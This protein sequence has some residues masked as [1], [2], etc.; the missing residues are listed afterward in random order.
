M[1][2]SDFI[3]AILVLV[4]ISCVVWALDLNPYSKQFQ[5]YSQSCDNMILEN[6]FCKGNWHDNPINTFTVSQYSDQVISKLEN[7]PESFI[8]KDCTIQDRKN[9][10]CSDES[11]QL[12]INV[13]DGLI[14]YNEA[15]NIRQISRIEWLQNKFLK[16]I[17]K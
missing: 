2:F 10:T 12:E 3:L 6:T 11:T 1:S 4:G 9:W 13:E 14:V 15:N 17:N 16:V 8:Y 7:Q 5:V